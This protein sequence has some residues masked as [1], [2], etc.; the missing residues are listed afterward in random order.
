MDSSEFSKFIKA[1]EEK[2]AE[3]LI[4]NLAEGEDVPEQESDR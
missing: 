2:A 4:E 3:Y 1:L